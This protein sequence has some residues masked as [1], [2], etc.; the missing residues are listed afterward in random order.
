MLG[1]LGSLGIFEPGSYEAIEA[2][3]QSR[4]P[5][6][7]LEQLTRVILHLYDFAEAALGVCWFL[8]RIVGEAEVQ[9]R[10]RGTR[11]L[12]GEP[13]QRLDAFHRTILIEGTHG[14]AQDWR[15]FDRW[16]AP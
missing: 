15:F 1:R 4:V 5:G 8:L 6:A 10:E 7:P 12:T 2:I 3:E 9:V 13:G 14:L 11:I 16:E